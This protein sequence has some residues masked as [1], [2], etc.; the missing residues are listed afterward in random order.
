MRN[1]VIST[2]IGLSISLTSINAEQINLVDG[3]NLISIPSNS[4]IDKSSIVFNDIGTFNGTAPIPS[5]LIENIKP[6]K[7][8][9][10]KSSG[11]SKINYT[12]A[13]NISIPTDLSIGWNLIGLP[14]YSSI[15]ELNNA[16][17]ASGYT[18]SDLGTFNGTAPIPSFLINSI[19]KN[20]GYWINITSISEPTGNETNTSIE[21]P[22]STPDLN[23]T[24]TT[25]NPIGLPP[26]VPSI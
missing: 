22:P 1:K 12:E 25:N 16:L 9:W 8:Y 7:G 2:L 13:S 18:Y 26:Q 15:N 23:S 3:W 21:E 14:S 5:F 17:N 10:I 6:G 4:S 20:K 24:D 11:E 19:D